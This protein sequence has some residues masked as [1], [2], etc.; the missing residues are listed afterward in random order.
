MDSLPL[1][2]TPDNVGLFLAFLITVLLIFL[3][4]QFFTKE[5]D[6]EM[7]L[8]FEKP[9]TASMRE[10][11]VVSIRGKRP[12]MEDTFQACSMSP[13]ISLYAVLDG[14]GGEKAAAYGARE[15]PL[16]FAEK[17]KTLDPQDP[18]H[19]KAAMFDLYREMDESFLELA[20]AHSW[21]DGTT[22]ISCLTVKNDDSTSIYV[23]NTGDSR[24]I[25]ITNYQKKEECK[26]VEMSSDHKPNKPPEKLR[27]TKNHGRVVLAGTW[28]VEGQLA[29]SRAIGDRHLKQWVIP[30]PEITHRKLEP[31]DLCV[32]LASDGVWDVLTNA[33]VADLCI[34]AHSTCTKP[35][36]KWV[37]E[38]AKIITYRA[39]VG[40]STDNITTL[41]VDLKPLKEA[42]V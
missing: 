33:T 4:N 11:G 31:Q 39:F 21:L 19:C 8:K 1:N 34:E 2:T 26:F 38:A 36:Q 41:V 37:Q 7:S 16:R 22:C 25:L 6:E 42:S 27:I 29:V 13:K 3:C 9:S 23:A 24:A 28:R 14:H 12:H 20:A 40:G 32:V 17:M 30:D 10:V 15:L 35:S 18:H 5:E